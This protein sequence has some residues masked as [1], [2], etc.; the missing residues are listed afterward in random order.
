MPRTGR[1][2]W[3][4][5][6][7]DLWP[8][9]QCSVPGGHHKAL[10]SNAISRGWDKPYPLQS[11]CSLGGE[12]CCEH[13]LLFQ[14]A[15]TMKTCV[16]QVS[17]GHAPKAHRHGW[18]ALHGY[19]I[20]L[21]RISALL[22]P[23]DHPRQVSGHCMKP[24]GAS[25][26]WMSV[27]NNLSSLSVQEAKGDEPINIMNSVKCLRLMGT[28]AVRKSWL[29]GGS[30]SSTKVLLPNVHLKRTASVQRAFW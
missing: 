1:E 2:R 20:H 29:F 13:L 25:K 15:F 9:A 11:W 21:T 16:S 4:V 23:W 14:Q 24:E 17:P 12:G 6:T 7:K 19:L 3:R 27:S 22:R 5:Q 10:T 30:V 26:A 8:P 28:K 18:S